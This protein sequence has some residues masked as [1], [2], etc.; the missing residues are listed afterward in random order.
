MNRAMRFIKIQSLSLAVV[1]GLAAVFLSLELLGMTSAVL[2][3]E[4]QEQE[5]TGYVN[6]EPGMQP[7]PQIRHIVVFTDPSL[8]VVLDLAGNAIGEGVHIG[9]VSCRGDNCNKKTQLDLLVGSDRVGYEYQFK[10]LL[11][12]DPEERRSVVAGT[13]TIYSGRQKA[14]FL[15]TAT[16]QDNR[17]GTV[18][19]TYVASRPDASFL[20]PM[21]PGTFEITSRP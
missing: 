18:S 6:L 13:G 17:D 10:T 21:S 7:L 11:A 4:P 1:I 9:A 2:A 20:I 19:V 12:L 14:R 16:F 8:H 15:F 5:L 3:Q